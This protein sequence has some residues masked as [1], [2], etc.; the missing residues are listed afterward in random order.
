MHKQLAR[1][2]KT[3]NRRT[4]F[5]ANNLW[6]KAC[7]SSTFKTLFDNK[8][9]IIHIITSANDCFLN[10]ICRP[11]DTC[12]FQLSWLIY[13]IRSNINCTLFIPLNQRQG[14]VGHYESKPEEIESAFQNHS[15]KGDTSPL[16]TLQTNQTRRLQNQAQIQTRQ[17]KLCRFRK[18]FLQHKL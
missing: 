9:T 1:K 13:I 7:K 17:E 5:Q 6:Q 2:S 8:K 3:I 11:S 14:N 10:F 15:Q 18:T 4:M 16:E 12:F